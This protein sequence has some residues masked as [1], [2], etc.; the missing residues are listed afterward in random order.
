MRVSQTQDNLLPELV[1]MAE[2]PHLSDEYPD[3]VRDTIWENPTESDVVLDLHVGTT[4]VYGPDH[5]R[6]AVTSKWTREQ[7][8]G[9]RQFV[10]RKAVRRN[11]KGEPDPKGVLVPTRARIPS[12]FD[13]GIQQTNCVEPECSSRKTFCRESSHRKNIVGGLGPQ[14]VNVSTITR[15]RLVPALD[16]YR[17]DKLAAEARAMDAAKK[18]EAARDEAL[19]A[20]GELIASKKE[21]EARD[22]LYAYREKDLAEREARIKALEESFQSRVATTSAPAEDPPRASTS[23]RQPAG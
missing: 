21:L 16:A 19:I 15:P 4:P 5:V 14:L 9:L 20:R 13:Q 1:P 6:R 23:K 22:S 10:I 3:E 17:A 11:E 2:Q 8:T 12:E 7:K 18:E